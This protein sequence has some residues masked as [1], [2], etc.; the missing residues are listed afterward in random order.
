M[1][2]AFPSLH[3]RTEKS[4]VSSEE[5]CDDGSNLHQSISFDDCAPLQ[6]CRLRTPPPAIDK[7]SV[8]IERK[9]LD[10]FSMKSDASHQDL[11]SKLGY[12]PG[13]P[14][15][16]SDSDDE[17]NKRN[18]VREPRRSSL[19]GSRSEACA[20]S[21]RASIGCSTTVVEV[22]IRGER[23]PVQRRRS[24]DFAKTIEI[25][26]VEPVSSLAES[27]S[28]LWL[29]PE[30]FMAMKTE[31]RSVV[32]K[33]KSGEANPVE[34]E[35]E[36]LRGLE[37]YMDRTIRRDKNMAWDS[38]L[39]EQ[40]EQELAG[41]FNPQRIADLYKNSAH[42]APVRATARAKQDHDDVQEY[43]QSPRTTKLMLR[44]CSM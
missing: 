34:R 39:F 12:G 4:S 32:S 36:T 31:R 27:M 37:K 3:E 38:V 24:I 9:P 19:K 14:G 1:T 26:E 13:S 40:D 10:R 43:L 6:P 8:R 41:R 44:R 22:Q 11:N 16:S 33:H 21:R 42:R 20:I 35:D 30:E 25:K 5:S 17:T 7:Q 29:Q 18:P 15:H 2:I 28:D 23:F